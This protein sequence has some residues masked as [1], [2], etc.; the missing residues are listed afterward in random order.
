MMYNLFHWPA[1]PIISVDALEGAIGV[2]Q[3]DISALALSACC[4]C[5]V[6]LTA[7]ALV[8]LPKHGRHACSSLRSK[9]AMASLFIS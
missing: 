2:K 8:K 7:R 4:A 1:L 6:H 9:G 3:V 5:D